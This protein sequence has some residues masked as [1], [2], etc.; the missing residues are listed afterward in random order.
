MPLD[1]LCLAAVREELS[2]RITGQKIDKVYQP[3]RDVLVLKLRGSAGAGRLL[4]SAGS[5]DMRVHLTEQRLENPAA[6]P[7]F[8]MLLR[9]YL[10]GAKITGLAQPPS[11]RVLELIFDTWDEAGAC[12]EKRL[13]LE[14]I[15][16]MSNVILVDSEAKIIDC[17]RRTGESPSDKRTLFPGYMYESPPPQEGKIAAQSVTEDEWQKLFES[18]GQGAVVDKWLLS[19]FYGLSPLICRE[20]SWRAYG[21]VDHRLDK[22]DDGGASLRREFFSLIGI[23]EPNGAEPWIITGED[24]APRDFSFTKILQYEGALEV[25]REEDF[26]S[27]LDGYYTR[28]SQIART[29]Q[30][31]SAAEKTV[32]NARDRLVR[33]LSAQREE[34]ERTARRDGSRECGDIIMA[35]MH[36][37]KKG[38]SLLSAQDFYSEDGG[39]REIALDPLKTPQQNAAKYY[40]DYT[41][42]RNAEKFLTEQIQLGESELEYLESVLGEIEL[43][44]GERD[45]SEIRRELEQTGYAKAQRKKKEKHKETSPMKFISSSG[46]QVLAGR[47]N[48]QNDKLTLKT[49][50]KSD[51]WLHAQK[52]HGAHVIVSCGGAAPDEKT[53]GE[54][55]AIAAYYSAARGGG[56]VPVDYT[57]VKYV[58]KPPGGRP[59]MVIYTNQKTIVAVP[60]EKLISGLRS[61]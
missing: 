16:R 28:A 36:L 40:K 20:I 51:V 18:R 19:A 8:C 5:G 37:M 45:L 42:A 22:A 3:E 23:A 12:S 47:N 25:R 14:L 41:K 30:R 11:E 44:E 46:M 52:R 27:M 60:D 1:A 7:M 49:A 39:T 31:A 15:G 34:L 33:K 56:K 61:E 10:T 26:S 53:L 32:R 21:S 55:A 48:T 57:L 2:L 9:K 17:L 59:G 13:V 29:R 54:A 50:F 6:P 35:N 4:V 38:Q 24:G 58:K 43:A